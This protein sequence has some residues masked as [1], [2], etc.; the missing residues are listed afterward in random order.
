MVHNGI[1]EFMYLGQPDTAALVPLWPAADLLLQ[2]C[3]PHSGHHLCHVRNRGVSVAALAAQKQ[4]SPLPLLAQPFL[5][6][7]TQKGAHGPEQL[8]VAGKIAFL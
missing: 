5:P 3:R 1:Q 4:A 8:F 7:Q 2:L 6:A